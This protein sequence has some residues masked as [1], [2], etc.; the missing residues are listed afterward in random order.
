RHT[1][2]SRDWSSDVCSSDLRLVREVVQFGGIVLQVVKL[3]RWTRCREV[4]LHKTLI[5]RTGLIRGD[6]LRPAWLADAVDR[7][8]LSMRGAEIGRA[9][10]RERVEGV[11]VGR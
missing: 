1:R 11:V 10:C 9:S 5:E 2:F 4:G 6:D 3:V 8:D 7:R